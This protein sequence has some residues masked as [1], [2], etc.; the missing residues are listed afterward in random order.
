[1]SKANKKYTYSCPSC[2]ELTRVFI[3][4]SDT[5]LGNRLHAIFW[6]VDQDGEPA[7]FGVT[8]T[9]EGMTTVGAMQQARKLLTLWGWKHKAMYCE[10]CMGPAELK[11]GRLRKRKKE[12]AVP[13]S[14]DDAGTGTGSP[15]FRRVFRDT[16][17]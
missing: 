4:G 2:G 10:H 17:V 8:G 7:L 11:I 1:M 5:P 3:K 12:E 13:A 6:G 15:G 14:S 9:P 16:M